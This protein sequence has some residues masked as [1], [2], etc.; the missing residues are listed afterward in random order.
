MYRKTCVQT[1][2]NRFVGNDYVK[3]IIPCENNCKLAT[4]L[5]LNVEAL[6]NSCEVK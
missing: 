2:Q 4:D 5:V 1:K 3:I 6:D